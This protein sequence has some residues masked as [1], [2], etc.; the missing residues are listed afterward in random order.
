MSISRRI[1]CAGGEYCKSRHVFSRKGCLII[2]GG[3]WAGLTHLASS[4]PAPF[5]LALAA[6]TVI[7]LACGIWLI[8]L[9]FGLRKRYRQLM[10]GRD[11]LNMDELLLRYGELIAS[12]SQRQDKAEAR[13][14]R[15]EN[16]VRR[17]VAG[18]GLVRYNAFRDTGSDLSFSLALLNR[19]LDG[20]VITSI[21]GRDENRIYGKPVREGQSGHQLSE[22][23]HAA[24]Q[25]AK[26][27]MKHTASIQS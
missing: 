25:E 1:R 6:V 19:D 7:Y 27:S 26:S 13:L 10:L 21:F 17:A 15:L 23:E 22:E 20:A 24:L 2:D 5:L 14:V 18:L 9:A 8:T 3:F 4:N 12:G 11:G 16:D